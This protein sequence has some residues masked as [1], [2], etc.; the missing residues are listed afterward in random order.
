[1][2]N[3]YF[4]DKWQVSKSLTLD[5]GARWEYWPTSTPQYPGGSVNYDP[6][7]NTLLLAG[8]GN[9]PMDLGIKSYKKNI[10]P[11]IGFAWRLNEK[12]VVR[13]GF[14]MSNSYRYDINWQ[15]PVKQ[16]QQLTAA[17]SFVAA[18]TMAAGFP[19]PLPVVIPADGI[20]R[21][22]PNQSFSVNPPDHPVPYVESWNLALQRT[23]R[24]DLSLEVAFVGNHAVHAS[25]S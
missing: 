21:N 19:A 8:I 3:L 15:F 4:Q 1:I 22:A 6:T 5:L 18:G 13:G 11:R 12:T 7:N 16:A 10:Y 24:G 2:Y 25:Y 14:G 17:N 23:L 20:I 9:V